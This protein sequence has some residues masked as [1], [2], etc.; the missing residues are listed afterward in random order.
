MK[1]V[2]SRM[3][4][5]QWAMDSASFTDVLFMQNAEVVRREEGQRGFHTRWYTVSPN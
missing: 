1:E 5:G 3:R 4:S 2:I